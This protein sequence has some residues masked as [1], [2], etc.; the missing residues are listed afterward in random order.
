MMK[1]HTLLALITAHCRPEPIFAPV[2][3]RAGCSCADLLV[4]E[5]N[6]AVSLA[7]ASSCTLPRSVCE[8][9]AHG[10]WEHN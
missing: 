8:R 5:V 4:G 3:L 6:Q 1:I 2:A 7:R 10:K 9:K